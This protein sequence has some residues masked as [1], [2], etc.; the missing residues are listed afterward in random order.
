MRSECIKVRGSECS[1]VIKILRS[2]GLARADLKLKKCGEFV[3]IPLTQAVPSEL[4]KLLKGIK[5][6]L[7]EDEFEEVVKGVTYKDLLKNELPEDVVSRLPRS[8]LIIGDIAV[9]HLP[10]EL[11]PYG[12]VVAEAVMKVAK[13]VRVVYATRGIIGD[14]RLMDLVHLGGEDRS[15]TIHKEYGV[16]IYVDIK[17]AYFNPSLSE[18][19]RRVA[20]KVSNGEVVMDL[21]AGVGPFALHILTLRRCRV[22]VADLNPSAV[23]CFLKSVELNRKKLKGEY[24][25][26]VGD[27]LKFIDVVRDGYVD[28]VIMNLPHKAVKYIPEVLSKVKVGGVLHV[29]CIAR[30]AS[31]LVE[32]VMKYS[33]GRVS[34]NEVVKVL[35]Y[36][37]FKYV[38]RADLVRVR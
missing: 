19:H 3:K 37:P 15:W 9:L 1:K 32:E 31:E 7:C 28:R 20:A 14:Y 13:N 10:P 6:E 11:L 5:W 24:L 27:A 35:D 33:E 4:S 36:A 8:Y 2:V 38:H 26:I 30:N 29:Y 21:F 34:V 18:E 16:R 23:S 22:Y 12:R 17:R 25:A